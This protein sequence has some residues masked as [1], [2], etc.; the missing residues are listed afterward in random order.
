MGR[1]RAR[2]EEGCR[3]PFRF[4]VWVSWCMVMPLTETGIVYVAREKN[5][6]HLWTWDT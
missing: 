1:R 3:M 2:Q 5:M 6:G 4:F